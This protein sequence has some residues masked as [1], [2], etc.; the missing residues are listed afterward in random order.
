MIQYYGLQI[1]IKVNGVEKF[2]ELIKQSKID[3]WEPIIAGGTADKTITK[4]IK[5]NQ[6]RIILH[7]KE[8]LNFF[9]SYKI[10]KQSKIFINQ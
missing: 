10:I 8:K 5:H 7:S 1:Y 3:N 4:K 6:K 9:D 2:I